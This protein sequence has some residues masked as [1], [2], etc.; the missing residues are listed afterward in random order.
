MPI[1]VSVLLSLRSLVRSRAALHLEILALRHQLQVLERSRRPRLRLTAADRLLWVWFS[2]I[3]TEWRTGARPRATGHRRRVAPAW[4]PPV[5]D[6]EEPTPHRPADRTGRC[7]R[8][9]PHDVSGQSALGC[10]SHPRRAAEARD[11]PESVH[12]REVHG[13]S[14]TPTVA[15]VADVPREP[16]R[17]GDGRRLLR[18][19]DRHVSP[20]VRA[21]DPRPRTP[22]RRACRGHRSPDLR[23]DGA[24]TP[25]RLSQRGVPVLP[26]AR[27][28]RRIRRRSPAPSRPCRSRRW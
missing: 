21:R 25:Q 1:V 13:A 16:R 24:T 4:V 6:L 23:V 22:T 28:R 3:W 2:R 15:D 14:P 9:D 27:S 18:G 10:T 19:P 26:A 7:P 11:R 17:P 20:A 12:R 5:L 8:V